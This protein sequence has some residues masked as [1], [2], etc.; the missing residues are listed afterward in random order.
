MTL[1]ALRQFVLHSRHAGAPAPGSRWIYQPVQITRRYS[2]G[3]HNH[4]DPRIA[5]HPGKF[6]GRF[7]HCGDQTATLVKNL[8]PHGGFDAADWRDDWQRFRKRNP[9]ASSPRAPVVP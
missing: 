8:H 6:S 2:D 4:D 5:D 9:P 1:S 7:T 3:T